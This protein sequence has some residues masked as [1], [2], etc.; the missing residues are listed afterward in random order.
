MLVVISRY[1]VDKVRYLKTVKEEQILLVSNN[2]ILVFSN[3]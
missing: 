2:G 3:V 1:E